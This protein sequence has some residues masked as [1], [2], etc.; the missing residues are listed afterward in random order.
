MKCFFL[1][2]VPA[3]VRIIIHVLLVAGVLDCYCVSIL[4]KSHLHP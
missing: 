3:V 2:V 4:Y 1:L